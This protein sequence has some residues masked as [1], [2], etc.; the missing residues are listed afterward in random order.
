[1]AAKT[2]PANGAQRRLWGVRLVV[3]AATAA[4]LGVSQQQLSESQPG[5]AGLADSKN[6]SLERVRSVALAAAEPLLDEAV[7]SGAISE[8]DRRSL[9]WRIRDRGLI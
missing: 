2:T 3:L 4:A 7:R 9:R 8:E 1:M 5:M 6:V